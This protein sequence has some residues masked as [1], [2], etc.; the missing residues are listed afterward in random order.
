MR[1]RKAEAQP[2]QPPAASI[3]SHRTFAVLWLATV[4][5]NIG[6]WMHD[7]GAGW[8]MTSLAPSPLWVALVQTATALP[9]F[10]LSLPAGALADIADRRRLLVGVQAALALVAGG[11]GLLVFLEQVSPAMLLLFTFAMGVGTALGAPAWQAIVPSLVPREALQQAVATNS[12]GVNLSRAIGPA[13]AGFII[14]ALGLAMPFLI[15]ALSFLAVVGVLL[16]W[17]PPRT[18]RRLPAEDLLGAMRTGLRYAWH[19]APLRATLVRAA[20]FFLFASA[21]WALLP[22]IA[23]QV[24]AGGA[25]LY[26]I[27]LGCVGAGAVLGAFTLPRLR[28]RLGPDNV[29]ALGTAGTVAALLALAG[30]PLRPVAALACLLAGASWIAVLTSLNVSMQVA[31]PDWVRARGLSIFVMVFFGSMSVGSITW[32]QT[33]TLL[34]L[35]AALAL[36]A[37]GALIAI[38]LTWRWK[39]QQGSGLDLAP[40]THWPAPLV[41]GE[42]A[43]DRGPVMVTIEYRVEPIQAEAFVA[44]LDELSHERRRDGAY[45]W[46]L[47]EDVAQPGRYLEYFLVASWL[48]HLRQHERVTR[49]D[50]DIQTR[51]L[52]FHAGPDQPHIEGRPVHAG[53]AA[54]D[55]LP[56]HRTA[57]TR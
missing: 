37:A 25:P 12:V 17:R 52:S 20:G 39:L 47:F 56:Q 3:F 14:T 11:L 10:L 6:T 40:S 15:N 16:W 51:A 24:L 44:T 38:P 26:G 33:A 9:V 1:D 31:L 7:V 46:G 23:R 13:L 49:A 45:A 48:E 21:Y 43:H 5:S 32:G 19:N 50:Q 53:L 28:A 34:G 22:L 18:E 54:A 55:D 29:V 27:L 57:P 2:L 4:L 35:P 8:L 42:V 30:L 36:A 41:D